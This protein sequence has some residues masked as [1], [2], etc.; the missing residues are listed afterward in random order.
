MATSKLTCSKCGR[1]R[2]ETE[3]FKQKNGERYSMCKDCLTQYI[4]NRDSST[5]LWIL[6]AF[7]VPY[8]EK[9]WIQ[10]S[11]EVY[12]KNPGKF[13]PKSVIG[14]YIRSMNM[15]QY[16]DY[17]Y[18]D[19]D[20]LNFADRKA[21]QEALSQEEQERRNKLEEDLR[22]RLESGDISQA[23]YD[24]LTLTNAGD[25]PADVKFIMPRTIDES[26]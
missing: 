12:K 22:E 15:A 20:K 1:E 18:A 14:R 26:Y 3:F 16:K 11:N 6:E 21:D 10:M 5:F 17:T 23:E 24:T 8:I 2:P 19:T 25:T 7:D 9:K 13:G 4:D